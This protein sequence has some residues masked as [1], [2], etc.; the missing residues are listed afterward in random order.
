MQAFAT[1]FT[2]P[3]ANRVAVAVIKF[4]MTSFCG[5]VVPPANPDSRT[6]R[7]P[8]AWNVTGNV[9]TAPTGCASNCLAN[10]C[11]QSGGL[12]ARNESTAGSGK[13]GV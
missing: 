3:S 10:C 5:S 2:V 1:P 7:N 4:S 9:A 13:I 12:K 11:A 8:L 6:G